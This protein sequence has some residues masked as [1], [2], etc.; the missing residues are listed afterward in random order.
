L[1]PLLARVCDPCLALQ[2]QKK[3]LP[4]WGKAQFAKP[5]QR[6]EFSITNLIA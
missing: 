3:Y 6:G 5:R 2:K 1:I 4:F